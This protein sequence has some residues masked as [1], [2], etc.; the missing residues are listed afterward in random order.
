MT[1]MHDLEITEQRGSEGTLVRLRGRID[2]DSSP[3][4]RDR[5]Q[6]VLREES[7]KTVTVDLA[8]VSYLDVSGIA[9][10]I[11]GLKIARSRN[12]GL[13]LQ[14]LQGRIAHLFEVTGVLH[15]F[16][17]PGGAIASELRVP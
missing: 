5:L 6:L 13:C 1:A 2:I 17:R 16:D 10:L 7:P 3:A 15:L 11:E 12:G 9:T 14:G 8:E 4:F